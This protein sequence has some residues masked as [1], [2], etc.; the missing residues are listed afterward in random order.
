MSGSKDYVF[1][2]SNLIAVVKAAGYS[3]LVILDIAAEVLLIANNLQGWVRS[4]STRAS[5]A[6]VYQPPNSS[7]CS[8]S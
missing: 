3:S 4:T 8:V 7:K 1:Q 2:P 6:T 5:T